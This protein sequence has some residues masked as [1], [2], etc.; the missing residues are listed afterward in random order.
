LRSSRCSW[1]WQTPSCPGSISPFTVTIFPS[2]I[3]SAPLR[4]W[5]DNRLSV[6]FPY[7]IPVSLCLNRTVIMARI[8]RK[9]K[10]R[11]QSLLSR[12]DASVGISAGHVHRL[13][14]FPRL[15]HP[16]PFHVLHQ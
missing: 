7:H 15:R 4:I 8:R 16:V 2:A 3:F 13:P 12:I 9:H 11:Y 5:F 6:L 1:L 10:E 14:L